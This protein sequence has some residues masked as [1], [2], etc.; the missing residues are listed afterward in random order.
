MRKRNE[1]QRDSPVTTLRKPP[2]NRLKNYELQNSIYNDSNKI[3]IRLLQAELNDDNTERDL[4]AEIE[5]LRK[6]NLRLKEELIHRE[7]QF[8]HAFRVR[9]ASELSKS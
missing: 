5:A 3:S 6:E 9:Y 8:N 2:Q 1:F 7:E 4:Y